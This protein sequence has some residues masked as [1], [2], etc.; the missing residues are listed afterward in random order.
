M[1]GLW[2]PPAP[3]LILNHLPDAS[4]SLGPGAASQA[5]PITPFTNHHGQRAA[6]PAGRRHASQT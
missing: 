3:A 2:S 5:K 1:G 4:S 6:C